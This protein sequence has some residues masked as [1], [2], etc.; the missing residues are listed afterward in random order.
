MDDPP[1]TAKITAFPPLLPP[2]QERLIFVTGLETFGVLGLFL[3]PTL[4]AIV[5]AVWRELAGDEPAGAD[6]QVLP[7]Q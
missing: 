4:L 2:C 6:R 1:L 5:V 3:G 7:R